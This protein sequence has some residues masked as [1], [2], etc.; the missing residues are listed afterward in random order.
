VL[1]AS[2]EVSIDMHRM[3][4]HAQQAKERVVELRDG[5]AGPV[6]KGLARFKIFEVATVI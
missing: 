1:C 2:G 6:T 5:P 3:L 4:V